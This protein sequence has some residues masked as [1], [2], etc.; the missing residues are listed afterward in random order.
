[1]A[2]AGSVLLNHSELQDLELLQ[3][4]AKAESLLKMMEDLTAVDGAKFTLDLSV[5]ENSLHI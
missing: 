4:E 2:Q 1:M 5:K 3:D